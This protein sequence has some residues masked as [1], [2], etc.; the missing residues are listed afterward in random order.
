[1]VMSTTSP[2]N[3]PFLPHDS[4]LVSIEEQNSQR[5]PRQHKQAMYVPDGILQRGT[6]AQ[7]FPKISPV[8]YFPC[9]PSL[10]H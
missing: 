7:Y 4:I 5:H 1:M 10:S 3:F 2:H 6:L 8:P 9:P